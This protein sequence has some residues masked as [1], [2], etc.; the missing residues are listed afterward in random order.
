M[1]ITAIIFD[2]DDTLLVEL[3]SARVA[4]LHA[5]QLAKEKHNLDPEALHQT[6]RKKAK[7]LWHASP[8]HPFCK[9]TAISSWEGLWGRFAGDDV[10]LQALRNWLPTY[11]QTAWQQG[12]AEFGIEDP[13]FAVQLSKAFGAKRRT[14][15]TVYPDVEPTLKDLQTKYKL[16]LLTNGAS[17]MQREK[18]AGSKLE[19][20]FEH[21][22]ISGEVGPRK[23]SAE[24]FAL[25]LKKLNTLPQ[26]TIMV[27]NSL[28]SDITGAKKAGIKTVWLNRDNT[29][30]EDGTI[31][32]CEIQN[33]ASLYDYLNGI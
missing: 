25:T 9:A 14:L 19:P 4:F 28:E 2:L 10:N 6:V 21:I 11:R 12:L 8:T 3:A 20:Y 18:L 26:N 22:I 24:I 13:Q 30:N 5:C 15:H 31:P 29:P 16:A 7:I 1:K 23:P 33:L 17:D 32:D 27:G